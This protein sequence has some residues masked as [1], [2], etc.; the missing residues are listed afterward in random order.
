MTDG[1]MR[2]KAFAFDFLVELFDFEDTVIPPNKLATL[3]Y[4]EYLNATLTA[5]ILKTKLECEARSEELA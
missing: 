2:V 5:E 3:I 4:R 1:K